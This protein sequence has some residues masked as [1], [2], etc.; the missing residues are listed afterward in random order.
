MAK[1][2]VRMAIIT[3]MTLVIT[4]VVAT[5]SIIQYPYVVITRVVAIISIIPLVIILL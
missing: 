2:R 4:R 3:I 1:N 5:I